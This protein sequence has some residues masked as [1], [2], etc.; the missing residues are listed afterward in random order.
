M[1]KTGKKIAPGIWRREDGSIALEATATVEGKKR[2][3]RGVLPPGATLEEAQAAR[4][5][6]R[7]ELTGEEADA[8]PITTLSDYAVGWLASKADRLRPR[9][10]TTYTTTLAHHILPQL[11]EV[12][13]VELTRRHIEGWVVYAETAVREDGQP[14]SR[15]T[16]LGW[17]R[18]LTQLVR[19]AVADHDLP[20][21][22]TD[23]V[24][25]PRIQTPAKREMGTLTGE[26]LEQLLTACA[27]HTPDRW[28]EVVV[29]AYTGIRAGE[30]YGL[31]WGDV[32]G[33]VLHIRQSAS[34]GHLTAPKGVAHRQVYACDQVQEALAAHRRQLIEAQHVGLDTGLVFPSSAGTARDANSLAKPLALAS[35]TAGLDLRVTPQVLR[36]TFNTL[37]ISA[38]VD[39]IVLRAQMGHTSEAMSQRYAGVGLDL[40][41][42]AFAQ[43]FK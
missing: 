17:W 13:L 15:P 41:R 39:R 8:P 1:D 32:A 43:A 27:E 24:Q 14:Y 34:K 25:P 33:D 20:R 28:A 36:R 6:L 31:R 5:R 30:L 42:K 40:K 21:D 29:L 23:R 37:L 16:V 4:E 26:E 11:G 12:Q 3:R 35:V 19:D 9:V 7:R 10:I 38:G 18:L 22:P 2:F